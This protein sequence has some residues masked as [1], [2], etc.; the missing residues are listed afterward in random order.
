MS[1]EVVI[2]FVSYADAVIIIRETKDILQKELRVIYPSDYMCEECN[3]S[4]FATET[5]V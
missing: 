4:I 2:T 5:K 3:L 1:D